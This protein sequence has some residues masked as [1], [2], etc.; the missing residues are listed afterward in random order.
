[1]EPVVAVKAVVKAAAVMIAE[2]A[3]MLKTRRL[4]EAGAATVCA[5]AESA[6]ATV[7][8]AAAESAAATVRAAAESAG[9]RPRAGGARQRAE[10]ERDEREPCHSESSLRE[11]GGGGGSTPPFTP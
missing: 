11:A 7:C 9:P 10:R 4:P 8:A 3:A 6:A 5:A 1:V 2:A